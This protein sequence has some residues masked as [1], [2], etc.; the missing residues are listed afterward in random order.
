MKILKPSET[1]KKKTTIDARVHEVP[2]RHLLPKLLRLPEAEDVAFG[3]TRR[4]AGRLFRRAS[5][6]TAR[7]RPAFG[8]HC[9]GLGGEECAS[10]GRPLAE[11]LKACRIPRAATASSK[12]K[13]LNGALAKAKKCP[14]PAAGGSVWVAETINM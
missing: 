7:M 5:R 10:L 1:S 12:L 2:N 9:G 8:Q 6:D 13:S 3:P 14:I 11:L 4:R